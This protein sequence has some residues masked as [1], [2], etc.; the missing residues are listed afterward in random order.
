MG[1][2]NKELKTKDKVVLHTQIMEGT[3]L[4]RNT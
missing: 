1:Q 3:E 4:E 2:K